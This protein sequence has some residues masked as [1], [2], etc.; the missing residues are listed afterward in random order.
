[1]SSGTHTEQLKFRTHAVLKLSYLRYYAEVP[2]QKYAAMFIG[3][4]EDTI[5]RWRNEDSSF[6][7][8]VL[9]AKAIWIRN[10]LVSTKAEFA[11]ERLEKEVFSPTAIRAKDAEQVIEYATIV[12]LSLIERVN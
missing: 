9:K 7:D 8:A 11:L 10:K 1:M 3:R 2:V 5:I 4:D 6:A 12:D